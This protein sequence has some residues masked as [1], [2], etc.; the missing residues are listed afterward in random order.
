MKYLFWVCA[1]FFAF[2]IEGQLSI[3][4]VTPNL[5]ALLVYYA[6]IKYQGLAGIF[7]GLL[8]G[9]FEDLL[10]LSILG[11]HML[12]KA[13]V[14]YVATL[15]TSGKFFRWTPVLGLIGVSIVTVIDGAT[16]YF[17]L[18]IFEKLP[19]E[20]ERALYIIIMQALLNTPFG[21]FLKPKHAD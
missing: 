3:L 10:T 6:A 17:S 4:R 13:L 20:P 5:T 18:G 9:F 12:G 11:P 2:L 7:T 16:V 19:Q 1:I 21:L 15:F 14:G 8:I